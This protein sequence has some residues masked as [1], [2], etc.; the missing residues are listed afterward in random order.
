MKDIQENTDRFIP[1]AEYD[2]KSETIV[3]FKAG[4]SR[5]SPEYLEALKQLAR[6]ATSITGYIVEVVG[7]ADSRG[8]AIMNEK[9]SE[10]RAKA[11]VS[12]LVQQCNLPVRQVVAPATIGE[13]QPAT[14]NETNEARAENRRVVAR[15]L[16]NK[17][18]ASI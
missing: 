16:V 6:T 3:K 18:L 7:F 17:R 4:S 15:I 5:I 8:G 9:L 2:V 11:V 10:D 12:F 1:L 13:Y 14:S